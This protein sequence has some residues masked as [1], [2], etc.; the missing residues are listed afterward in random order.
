MTI[1]TRIFPLACLIVTL[2]VASAAT[3]LPTNTFAQQEDPPPAVTLTK[4]A[5]PRGRLPVY[6]A[7]VVTQEQRNKIYVLQA[8]F[9]IDL[10]KLLAE[11]KKVEKQR[12]TE[13]RG[14]LNPD[15]QEKVDAWVA[16]AKAKR[17]KR[18]KT[19]SP[20]KITRPTPQP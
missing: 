6:Y 15:Q 19:S 8:K 14:V 17:E 12:D 2:A 7:R 1:R 5:K 18:R 4:R 16:E 3:A 20:E 9:Q 11:L 13:I 10:D